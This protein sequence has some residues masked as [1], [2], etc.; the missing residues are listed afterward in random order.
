VAGATVEQVV[1]AAIVSAVERFLTHEPGLRT[2]TDPEDVHQ[3]R[4]A[5][6]RLRSDL[7]TFDEFVAADWAVELRTELQWLGGELGAV[8]DL[9]VMRDRL[10]SHAASLPDPEAESARHAVARLAS[11]T[12]LA[13]A[14]IIAALGSTRYA[15]ARAAMLEA[16][17]HPRTNAAASEPAPRALRAVVR[18]PWKRLARAAGALGEEPTDEELH[19]VRVRVKRA[20]YATEAAAAVFGR[21]ARRLAAA[22]AHVQDV[23]GEH[24]DAVVARQWLVKAAIEAPAEAFAMGALAQYEWRAARE[25]RAAFPA[26]WSAARR[27]GLRTWMR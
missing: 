27:P 9:E 20:R 2:G 3:A 11:E 23:L 16:A 7:R 10:Q 21:P 1:R 4:V 12:E 24:Q 5:T 13:R 8:R 26:A 18:R 17:D 6:R 22:L 14:R 15:A 25:A 19:A